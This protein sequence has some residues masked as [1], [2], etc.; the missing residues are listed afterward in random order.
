V[1]ALRRANFRMIEEV[2]RVLDD[3]IEDG[4]LN[5]IIARWL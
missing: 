1:I 2:E 5:E 4:T 3:I